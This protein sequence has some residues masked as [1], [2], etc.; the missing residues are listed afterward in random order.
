MKRPVYGQPRTMNYPF[1]ID[2]GK[3]SIVHRNWQY[4]VREVPAGG[5][6]AM[7]TDYVLTALCGPYGRVMP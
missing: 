2:W 3:E 6:L 1:V 7:P 5:R 4:V